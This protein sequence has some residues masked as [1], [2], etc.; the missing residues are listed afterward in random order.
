MGQQQDHHIDS[1]ISNKIFFINMLKEFCFVNTKIFLY[2]LKFK[3][4]VNINHK[5]NSTNYNHKQ[6]IIL[7]HGYGRNKTDWLWFAYNLA[8]QTDQAIFSVNLQ[9]ALG[10][11]Q[12]IAESLNNSINNIIADTQCE[13][14]TLIGHSMGGVVSAY[15]SEL[16]DDNKHIIKKVITLGSP[17]HGT[18]L[19]V[20]GLGTNSRQMEPN[21]KFL[22]DL[23]LRMQSSNKKYFNIATK[24]DNL[25]FPWDSALLINNKEQTYTIPDESHLGLLYSDKVI[26]KIVTWL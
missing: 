14:I 17:L 4:L 15:V 9:P 19:S 13:E 20:L 22:Q 7:V 26:D 5:N 25:I 18:K 12:Q 6:A 21:T 3:P 1:Q 16:L 8:K 10:S 24:I 2:P 11:I 23:T